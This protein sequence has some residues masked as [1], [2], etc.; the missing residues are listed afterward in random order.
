MYVRGSTV[1]SRLNELKKY[2]V[3]VPF[4]RQYF[5]DGSLTRDGVDYNNSVENH[6]VVYYIGGIKYTDNYIPYSYTLESHLPI[7]G[8]N[9]F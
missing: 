2:A 5:G 8:G 1:N 7:G 9:L 4:S 3:G 6:M